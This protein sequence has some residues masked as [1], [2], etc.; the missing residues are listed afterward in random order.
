MIPVITDSNAHYNVSLAWSPKT[1]R[2][3]LMEGEPRRQVVGLVRR[4]VEAVKR[5]SSSPCHSLVDRLTAPTINHSDRLMVG[6]WSPGH[7][8][9]QSTDPVPA[10]IT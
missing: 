6:S 5:T 8:R 3:T 7:V 2:R 10:A 9:L 4:L 1:W